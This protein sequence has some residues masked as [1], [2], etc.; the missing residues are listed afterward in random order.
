MKKKSVSPKKRTVRR[1]KQQRLKKRQR[2]LQQRLARLAKGQQPFNSLA[3]ALMK[4]SASAIHLVESE[5]LRQL[6][7]LGRP[8]LNINLESQDSS[9]AFQ[10]QPPVAQRSLSVRV[11]LSTPRRLTSALPFESTV[12]R[13]EAALRWVVPRHSWPLSPVGCRPSPPECQPLLLTHVGEPSP[14]VAGSSALLALTLP[15]DSRSIAVEPLAEKRFQEALP[16]L[17]FAPDVTPA[18]RTAPYQKTPAPAKSKPASSDPAAASPPG[19]EQPSSD[20]ETEGGGCDAV[21]E[22]YHQK[23]RGLSQDSQSLRKIGSFISKPF[24]PSKKRSFRQEFSG[25]KKRRSCLEKSM[26]SVLRLHG[27]SRTTGAGLSVKSVKLSGRKCLGEFRRRSIGRSDRQRRLSESTA[28]NHTD[29]HRRQQ[30][31]SAAA[32]DPTLIAADNL[33]RTEQLSS[34]EDGTEW[35]ARDAIFKVYHR[36]KKCNLSQEGLHSSM[37]E[38]SPPAA[39]SLKS[40]DPVPEMASETPVRWE[41]FDFDEERFVAMDQLIYHMVV[42]GYSLVYAMDVTGVTMPGYEGLYPHRTPPSTCSS[43]DSPLTNQPIP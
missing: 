34:D 2:S 8:V 38:Q 13:G 6:P 35:V 5:K 4:A 17:S 31:T 15:P 25:A 30:F 42:T 41:G 22:M 1:R 20:D 11:S 12:A 21:F 27:G 23:D 18:R 37:E 32:V 10:M 7:K 28:V 9:Y 14:S 3:A 24:R 29:N 16:S 36:E 26:D 39:M 19:A 43:A 40:D 33:P